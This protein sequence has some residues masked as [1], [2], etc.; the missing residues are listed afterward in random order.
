MKIRAVGPKELDA[1]AQTHITKQSL[2]AVLS[3]R[4][5]AQSTPLYAKDLLASF[6]F[7]KGQY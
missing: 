6:M 5:K 1:P 4:L 2:F 3:K 7:L